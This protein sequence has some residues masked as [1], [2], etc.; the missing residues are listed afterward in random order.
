MYYRFICTA[1][2]II[3]IPIPAF[4]PFDH[5]TALGYFFGEFIPYHPPTTPHTVIKDSIYLFTQWSYSWFPSTVLHIWTTAVHPL[6]VIND[7]RWISRF[8]NR[9][10]GGI[11]SCESYINYSSYLLSL[12]CFR[13]Y[14]PDIVGIKYSNSLGIS[15]RNSETRWKIC[16][17]PVDISRITFSMSFEFDSKRYEKRQFSPTSSSTTAGESRGLLTE[18]KEELIPANHISRIAS[19][20]RVSY[21]NDSS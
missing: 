13:N 17:F 7:G 18:R 12:I 9:E 4:A 1:F 3:F 15:F 6:F 21:I 20:N 11:N 8:T 5:F 16:D 14:I 10:K 2:G 19:V